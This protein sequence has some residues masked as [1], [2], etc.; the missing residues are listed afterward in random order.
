MRLTGQIRR[1]EG[2]KTPLDPN[3][4]YRPI[5]RTTRRFN[6]L[7]VPRKL[8][9]SLPFASKAPELSKQRK[10]T[11][12]QSRAVVMGEDEKKAVTLLQ[13]IQTLKKDKSERRKAK[14]DERKEAYRKKVG[15]KD[16]KREEK[17]REERR[18]RFKKEGLKRKRE[19]MSE[20]KGRGK[21]SRA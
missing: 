19:E 7:K 1:E 5:Q 16:E 18:E 10:P 13:Q 20:G 6:P 12:M 17:I 21:K 9:A 11:Y 14:Q 8:A 2:L 3:S 15:E 4:A